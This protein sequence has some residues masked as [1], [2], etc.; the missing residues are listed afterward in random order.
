MQFMIMRRS[1]QNTEEGK[2]PPAIEPGIFLHPS[3][4]GVR[5][6]RKDGQWRTQPGPF[7]HRELV[8][9]LT[10]IE[11][12]SFEDAVEQVRN[13]PVPD[14]SALFEIRHAGCPGACL[15]F[16]EHGTAAGTLPRRDV[17][18]QRYVVMLRSDAQS[19]EDLAPAPEVVDLMNRYNEAAVQAGILLAGEGLKSSKES[20]RIQFCNSLTSVLDGPFT[21]VKELIAGYWMLQAESL[22]TAA[23][24]AKLYPYP[25]DGDLVLEVREVCELPDYAVS[26]PVMRK[27]EQQ[28]RALYVE[29][30]LLSAV[31]HAGPGA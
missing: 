14:A 19:E 27:V 17:R 6:L 13:W 24:W 16:D 5:L 18:Y 1:N 8:A 23:A 20:T 26:T 3:A 2:L 4:E 29:A 28:M 12:E 10:V 15:G 30:S 31:A 21:D 7:A 22:Q 25:V 9:S 11:A